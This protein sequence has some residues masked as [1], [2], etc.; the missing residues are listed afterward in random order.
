MR[1]ELLLEEL[2]LLS[3]ELHVF[4]W[5]LELFVSDSDI[6]LIILS[7]FLHEGLLLLLGQVVKILTNWLGVL[8]EAL[9]NLLLVDGNMDELDDLWLLE[10]PRSDELNLGLISVS[11]EIEAGSVGVSSDLNPAVTGLNLSIPTVL[12]IMGHLVR[13]MLSKP[14]ALWPDS[15]I[16]EELVS[17]SHE[18]SDGLVTNGALSHSV[19]HGEVVDHRHVLL[20]V[21]GGEKWEAVS[22]NQVELVMSLVQRINE[23]LDLSHLELSHSEETLLWPNLISKS[24]TQLSTCKWHLAVVE[25]NKSPEVEE[26]TLSGLRTEVTLQLTSW[27]NLTREHEV[28]SLSVREIIV[29]LRGLD[30]NF[31]DTSIELLSC[32]VLAVLLMLLEL[33]LLLLCQLLV[34]GDDLGDGLVNE[35][36]SPVALSSLGILDHEISELF[37]V[38]LKIKIVVSNQLLTEVFKTSLKVM[39]VQ[40]SSSMSSSRMKWFFHCCSTLLLRADPRGP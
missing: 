39:Q 33:G 31:F 17:T 34:F 27:S 4:S 37:N 5:E 25:L 10:L 28:E 16:L 7:H 19:A 15:H 18:V 29:R 9:T 40:V 26:D 13:S 3:L 24:N 2:L 12:S 20:L 35:L 32:V 23:V 1:D 22:S 14:D 8:L 30:A 38:T 6:D 11:L 36:V 21:L